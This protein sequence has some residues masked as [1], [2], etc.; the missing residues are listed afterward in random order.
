VAAVAVSGFVVGDAAGVRPT[1]DRDV[2]TA[3]TPTTTP[4][5][6]APSVDESELLTADEVAE[7]VH[8]RGWSVEGTGTEVGDILTGLPCGLDDF[9]VRSGDH[10][11]AR[12]MRASAAR[13]KNR[14]TYAHLIEASPREGRAQRRFHRATTLLA[15]CL[16]PGAH[17][18]STRTPGQVGD[19][20]LQF[21]LRSG[22]DTHTVGVARTGVYLTMVLL[23]QSDAEVAPNRAVAALLAAAVSRLCTFP[24]G[25]GCAPPE[26]DLTLR[27]PLPAGRTPSMLSE[28]DLPPVSVDDPW[29][30][31]P[32][33]R[34]NDNPAS[35]SCDNT[36]F[37]GTFRN[38]TWSRARTRTF[39]IPEGDLPRTFGL[40]QT[41]GALPERQARKLI[42]QV[43]TRLA[44]CH[45]RELSTKVKEVRRID[46][47]DRSLTV[48]RLDIALSD[49]R[50][51]TFWM[52]I[53]RNGTGIAQLGFL[54]A[55]GASLTGD[56]FVDLAERAV[57]RLGELGAPQAG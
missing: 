36:S 45:D 56:D 10:A 25:G 35:S 1:L 28:F 51:I 32:P 53:V 37:S 42:S 39:V 52:A 46:R 47:A 12:T 31:T 19:E 49:T 29:I 55:K 23:T 16:D 14:H 20:A 2:V 34:A 15:G 22:E 40:S 9:T 50:S 6:V 3:P 44:S 11:L 4:P 18:A 57:A 48:W 13:P 41:V 43:R 21:V 26:P 17:L 27:D 38:A 54:P 30:G 5:P 8:S 7:R 33:V 24:G